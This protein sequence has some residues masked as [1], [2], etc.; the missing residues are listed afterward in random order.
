M[1]QVH[2]Q[3]VICHSKKRVRQQRSFALQAQ[4]EH[5]LALA[6]SRLG[7]VPGHLDKVS[8]QLD[9]KLLGACSQQ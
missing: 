2:R 3:L 1:A 5:L 6:A 9:A 8:P 7:A 4:Q